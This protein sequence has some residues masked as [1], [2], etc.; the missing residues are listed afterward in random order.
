MASGP[1]RAVSAERP[2]EHDARCVACGE[3][4]EEVD[5]QGEDGVLHDPHIRSKAAASLANRCSGRQG[6]MARC[7]RLEGVGRCRA[8]RRPAG[9]ACPIPA[10][11]RH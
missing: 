8:P 11:S 2:D 7:G 6:Q 5:C 10:E 4:E 9:T 3:D 1:P